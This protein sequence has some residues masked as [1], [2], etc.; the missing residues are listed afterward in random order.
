[1]TSFQLTLMMGTL[2]TLL[3]IIYTSK[4]TNMDVR[5]TVVWVLWGL[6]MFIFSLFPWLFDVIS[7][8]CGIATPTSTVFLVFIF[9]GYVMTYYVYITIS[10]MQNQIKQ[11]TYEIAAL[12]KKMD[13]HE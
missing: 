12:R 10:K 6:I 13:D 1:M 2:I 5:Y 9:L 3:G 7:N 4:K 11:L 8:I